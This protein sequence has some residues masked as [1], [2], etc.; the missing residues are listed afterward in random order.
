M[1]INKN[2]GLGITY[3]ITAALIWAAFPVMTRFGVA[4]SNFDALDMT[5]IRFITSGI[6]VSPYLLISKHR[7]VPFA[8]LVTMMMGL[9]A[10]YMLTIALGLKFSPVEFFAVI[11]PTSMII[12]SLLLNRFFMKKDISTNEYVGIFIIMIGV[13]FSGYFSVNN[14]DIIAYLLFILGGLLWA[15][16]TIS[17]QYYCDSALYATALVSFSSMIIYTPLYIYLKGL[18]I[19]LVPIS[20][21][22]PQII[23][24]GILV[25]IVALFFYSKSVFLLG[26]TLGSVFA[27]LV[28]ALAILISAFTL[29]E[30]P[31][32]FSILGLFTITIG[33]VITIF[34]WRSTNE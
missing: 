26:S 34:K 16:Y 25:S 30:I 17:S 1:N 20:T 28:P 14:S 31:S 9:G 5:F 3:G 8:G 32:L 29:N 33:M 13:V 23:Y 21:L 22:A 19:F 7:K 11:T 6:L 12:F 18:D 24:Q 4:K 27:A 10:P 15:I 2:Y